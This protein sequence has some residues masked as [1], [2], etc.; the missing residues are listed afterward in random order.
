MPKCNFVIMGNASMKQSL[1]GSFTCQPEVS[2]CRLGGGGGVV[3]S[4]QASQLIRDSK[5]PFHRFIGFDRFVPQWVT[6]TSPITSMDN[7]EFIYSGGIHD[8]TV[9]Y[10]L[11]NFVPIGCSINCFTEQD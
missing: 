4:Q 6:T 9:C 3:L 8:L 7:H 5:D 1:I 2:K 11:L 10:G